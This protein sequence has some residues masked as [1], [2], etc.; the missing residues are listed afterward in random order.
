MK[1][2]IVPVDFSESTKYIIEEAIYYA[3]AT[4]SKVYLLH[5]ASL[6]LGF[7]IGD[8][9]FQYLPELEEA[10][11]KE[12]TNELIKCEELLKKAGVDVEIIIK[13][14][15]P[16]DIILKETAAKNA[17]LIIMSS[18]G[19]GVFLEV[20]LGSVSKNVIQKSKVPVLIV[21]PSE[22]SERELVSYNDQPD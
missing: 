6:D 2:I 4:Q 16:A 15:T 22:V 11:M 10:G 17:N 18:H 20:I 9:G 5:V 19:R 13:Q 12:E 1:S 21:P 3:K 8:I 14:G 7:V